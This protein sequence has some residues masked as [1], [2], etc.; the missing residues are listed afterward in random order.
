MI[1]HTDRNFRAFHAVIGALTCPAMYK[2]YVHLPDDS[3]PEAPEIKNNP[4]F[5]PY[6]KDCLGAIDGSHFHITAATEQA[7][8][9]RNRKGFLSQNVLA[10]C[11]F[12]LKFCYLLTG[13]EGSMAD[14]ALFNDAR[15][16]D[17]HIPAGKYYLADAGFARSDYLLVPYRGVRYHLR[18]WG[19][20]RS[21]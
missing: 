12:D 6:F 19:K 8:A 5:H 21:R 16:R 18:E 14:S 17:F 1:Q 2:A 13:W 7:P 10:G 15:A 20:A 11:T 3:S 9:C 4:K